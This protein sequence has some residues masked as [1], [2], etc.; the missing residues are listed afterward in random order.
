MARTALVALFVLAGFA[1]SAFAA[2]FVVTKATDSSDGTCDADCSLREAIVAA[3]TSPGPDRVILGTTL[4]YTLSVGGADP[5]GVLV[6]GSGDLDILD[7]LT[8]DGNGSTVNGGGIDRVFEIQGVFTVTINNLSVVNGV[9]TG[10]VSPGGGIYVGAGTTLVL[11]ASTVAGNST[12]LETGG[13]DSGGGIAV[14]GSFDRPSSQTTLA[15]LTL[16]N[17]TV[18]GNTGL[19]G[20]GIVCVLCALTVSNSTINGNVADGTDG[21]GIDMV[22]NGSTLSILSSNLH[23]NAVGAG[24]RGGALSVPFGNGLATLSRSRIVSNT[25]TTGAAISGTGAVIT[26][27]NNWWGCS[28]GPG[29]GGTGCAVVPNGTAGPVTDGPLPGARARGGTG[30][31]RRRRFLDRHGRSDLQLGLDRHLGGRHRPQR[32]YGRVR[33]HARDIRHADR[34]R[35]R[36]AKR[37]IF[38]RRAPRA[39]PASPQR[40]THSRLVRRSSSATAPRRRCRARR[41]ARCSCRMPFS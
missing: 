38:S 29:T 36:A 41:S 34:A 37:P 27:T 10:P 8:I 23:S 13:R 1:S 18:S 39:L 17:S 33:R 6:P 40:S 19:N 9:A 30:S 22:G 21:G 7:A 24:G 11:D 2:D 5:S 20:G 25:A 15:R 31:D 14:V 26:A 16:S 12:A 4:T 3:N 32:H 28:F 35:R